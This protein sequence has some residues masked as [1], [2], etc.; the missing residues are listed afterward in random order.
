MASPE[1]EPKMPRNFS[2]VVDQRVA[3]MGYP[4][5]DSNLLYLLNNGISHIITLTDTNVP[6][7]ERF[8][9]IEILALKVQDFTPPTIEQ[10]EKCLDF[11]D[12]WN[13]QNQ[14]VAVHC[15]FG[16]GRTGTVLAC[17]LV[18]TF[19]FGPEEA[20]S[21][22]REMRPGSVET[23]EQ[24]DMVKTFSEHLKQSS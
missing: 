21:K 14:A 10:I 23:S 19:N 17:Y 1:L 22:L 11:I 20:I 13:K 7:T 4:D 16:R 3:G 5:E 15:A 24:E 2:W 12:V 18:K 8:P 6:S 9:E